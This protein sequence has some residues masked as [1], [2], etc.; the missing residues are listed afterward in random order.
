VHAGKYSCSFF[1]VTFS[2]LDSILG[3]TSWNPYR[4][5]WVIA[6]TVNALYAYTWDIFMDWSL[7]YY[8]DRKLTIRKNR[9][10][11]YSAVYIWAAV[12]NLILRFTWSLTKSNLL[13]LMSLLQW[14]SVVVIA[15]AEILRRGQWNLFRL[16]NEHL[17][18]CGKFRAVKELQLPV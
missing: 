10:Y 12:S 3:G 7:L 1:V 18:N 15:A 13:Q 6:A 8:K 11:P 16:E 9:I 5:V 17:N 14:E 4:T 2:S